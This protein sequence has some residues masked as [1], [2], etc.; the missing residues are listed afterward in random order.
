MREL[1]GAGLNI[2]ITLLFSRDVYEQ[3]AEAYIAGLEMR[4]RT[5]TSAASPASRASSS[6]A[7]TAKVDKAIDEK[8][9]QGENEALAA[10]RGKV[11]V[12][13]AKLA[14][15]QYKQHLLRP[16]LGSAGEA[17]R[18]SAA[19]ALGLHRH[20]EQGLFRRPLC[21]LADRRRHRQHH[22]AGDAGSVPRS[23]QSAATHRAGCRRGRP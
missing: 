14:Y 20:Q 21:R 19:P 22:A 4:P 18:A 13:N 11:A 2:N 15:Q 1:L 17:R 6:A 10:L 23:R 7:S 8:L 16:A 3:V 9:K 5:T 12:A